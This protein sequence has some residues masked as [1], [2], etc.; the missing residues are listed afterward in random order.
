[1]LV[2]KKDPGKIDGIPPRVR[3]AQGWVKASALK[4]G[5]TG[6]WLPPG[7]AII[8]T[9]VWGPLRKGQTTFEL[10]KIIKT[11]GTDVAVERMADR[12]IITIARSKIRFGTISK[13]TKVLAMCDKSKLTPSEAVIE[14]VTK[15]KLGGDPVVTVGCLDAAGNPAA[16]RDEQLGAL[17]SKPAWLPPRR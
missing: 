6:S 15:P 1:M 14:K 9:R 2:A 17:R 13:G 12:T 7:D 8:G 5:D 11:K 16:S 3:V 10:G 4:N